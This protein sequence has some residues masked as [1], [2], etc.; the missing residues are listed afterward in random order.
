MPICTFRDFQH[1]VRWSNTEYWIQAQTV[2]YWNK[3]AGF[4]SQKNSSPDST[5]VPSLQWQ[6][7]KHCQHHRPLLRERYLLP[8]NRATKMRI[9]TTEFGKHPQ[10]SKKVKPSKTQ[11]TSHTLPKRSCRCFNHV[12]C[13]THNSD[14]LP[15]SLQQVGFPPLEIKSEQ[16]SPSSNLC[17]ANQAEIGFHPT[18]IWLSDLVS[19]LWPQHLKH[20]LGYSVLAHGDLARCWDF[21]SGQGRQPNGQSCL[22]W[23]GKSKNDMLHP[24]TQPKPCW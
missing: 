7:Q 10:K 22:R 13:M 12:E 1:T 21:D 9:H 6:K 11:A 4:S 24:S 2:P 20:K 23:K 5:I 14:F 15:D 16:T 8:A 17:N 3:S 19:L 18:C